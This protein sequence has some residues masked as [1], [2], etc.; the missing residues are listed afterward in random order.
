LRAEGKAGER[1]GNKKLL[2]G[3]A[4]ERSET[5]EGPFRIFSGSAFLHNIVKKTLIRS[6]G[7]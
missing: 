5:D 3:E 2:P 1:S 4:G 7:A 6:A